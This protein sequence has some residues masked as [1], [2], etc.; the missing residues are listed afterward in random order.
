MTV[1]ALASGNFSP[2]AAE[3]E[4]ISLQLWH[5]GCVNNRVCAYCR[6]LMRWELGLVG[7]VVLVPVPVSQRAEIIS[8]AEFVHYY[9][10][11]YIVL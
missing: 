10:N 1:F 2:S 3:E 5:A 11:S 7:L 6:A 4:G 8:N 9:T